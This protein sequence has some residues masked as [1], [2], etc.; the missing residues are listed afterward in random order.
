MA[1]TAAPASAAR[2]GTAD[3]AR[4]WPAL[5]VSLL[6]VVLVAGLGGLATDTGPGTWYAELEQPAW[7][8]PDWLFGPVW[9]ALY[10]LMA[11]AA[12]LVW[13]AGGRRELVP[14]GVQLVLNLA[15]SWVFFAGEAPWPGVAVIVALAVAIVVTI[16][17]FRRR[18][19]VAAWLLAPYLAWVLYATALNAAIALLN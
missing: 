2:R 14:Y 1:E 12:W 10:L 3:A 18:S 4:Q 9:S 8:P 6:A 17:A 13:R 19:T 15:W 7:N 11:V 5:A 16:V